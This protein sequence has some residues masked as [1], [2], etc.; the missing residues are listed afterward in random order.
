[1]STSEF[2]LEIR[3]AGGA[4]V[5]KVG[6]VG[7]SGSTATIAFSVRHEFDSGMDQTYNVRCP[8]SLIAYTVSDT[9]S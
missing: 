3:E 9:N 5:A 6:T 1:V 7:G 2:L 4:G 8:P